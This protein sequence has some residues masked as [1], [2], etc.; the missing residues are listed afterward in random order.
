MSK[1]LYARVPDDTHDYI[2]RRAEAEGVS[3]GEI[4][5]RIVAEAQQ[6][7]AVTSKS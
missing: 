7:D 5:R 2:L 3:M 6:S 4:V 1:V